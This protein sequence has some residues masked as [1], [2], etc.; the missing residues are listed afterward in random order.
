MA[1][2]AVVVRLGAALACVVALGA[3]CLG[4]AVRLGVAVF[5][6]A[7]FSTLSA[8]APSSFFSHSSGVSFP[9]LSNTL[10]HANNFLASEACTRSVS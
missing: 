7:G 1:F 6:A 8:S 2:F 10:Y 9:A 4:A 3:A 5:L